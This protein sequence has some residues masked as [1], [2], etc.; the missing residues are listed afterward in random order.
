MEETARQLTKLAPQEIRMLFLFCHGYSRQQIADELVVEP[1]TVGVT[2]SHIYDKLDLKKLPDTEAR[3]EILRDVYCPYLNRI[4]VPPIDP[5]TIK[6][7][8]PE[9]I[10]DPE[11]LQGAAALLAAIDLYRGL[12]PVDQRPEPTPEP[13]SELQRQ[14]KGK[15]GEIILP[16]SPNTKVIYAGDPPQKPSRKWWVFIA[17]LMG[18]IGLLAG[19]YGTLKYFKPTT[20]YVPQTQI[21]EITT[22][23]VPT[24]LQPTPSPIVVTAT[25]LPVVAPAA[26]P[27]LPSYL[28][29]GGL[30]SFEG[31]RV[32]AS[33]IGGNPFFW[34]FIIYND[35]STTVTFS[36]SKS[37]L[38]LT[39]DL[40][41][42]YPCERCDNSIGTM[43][44]GAGGS[45]GI[46]DICQ[47]GFVGNLDPK[48][49]SLILTFDKILDQTNLTWRVPVNQ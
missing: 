37:Y 9:P 39:D 29:P 48:A 44:I 46:G 42:N 40:G 16:G 41:N 21:I 19:V 36:T 2:F 49:R 15:S 7:P 11:V 17:L 32:G 33:L 43:V 47:N 3:R 34:C 22:T 8:D 28:P 24:V 5:K 38:H 6:R 14:S 13:I 10:N 1:S 23:P 20:V 27:T 26:S 25:P 18:L 4:K 30:Y 35:R 45:N 31:I 12:Q